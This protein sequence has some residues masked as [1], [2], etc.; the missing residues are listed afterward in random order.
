VVAFAPAL[1]FLIVE[2]ALTARVDIQSLP[3]LHLAYSGQRHSQQFT[4]TSREAIRPEKTAGFLCE[5]QPLRRPQAK[6]IAATR[7]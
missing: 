7:V 2:A 4:I 5:R 1:I 3:R 6:K